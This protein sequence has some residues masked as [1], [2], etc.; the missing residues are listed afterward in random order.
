MGNSTSDSQNAPYYNRC[1]GSRHTQQH[2]QESTEHAHPSASE[3]TNNPAHYPKF[4]LVIVLSTGKMQV[5]TRAEA[6]GN[7]KVKIVSNPNDTSKAVDS[8]FF[9]QSPPGTLSSEAYSGYVK[10]YSAEDSDSED[11]EDDKSSQDSHD[12]RGCFVQSPSDA[13]SIETSSEDSEVSEDHENSHDDFSE[14]LRALN[15]L[16]TN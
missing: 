16:Q 11:S 5:M 14:C 9:A 2:R 3:F 15:R 1:N 13:L 10:G 6:Y 4:V 7:E 12:N 8:D